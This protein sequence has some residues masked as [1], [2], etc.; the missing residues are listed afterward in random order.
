MRGQPSSKLIAVYIYTHFCVYLGKAML[1]IENAIQPGTAVSVCAYV[2][3]ALAG[4][5]P[6][7]HHTRPQLAASQCAQSLPLER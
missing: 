4:A 1:G 5:L 2:C 7:T 6:S 3:V